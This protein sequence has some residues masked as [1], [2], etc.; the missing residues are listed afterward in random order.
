M[1]R[2]YQVTLSCTTNKYKPVACIVKREQTTDED[3]TLKPDIKREIINQGIK[4]I[5][6]KRLWCGKDLQR[7]GYLKVKVRLYD[8][9][10]IAKENE[11]RDNR[12]K[13]EKYNSG[14]WVRPKA[15]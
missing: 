4:T 2:E 14:E 1:K 5:C 15:K 12:I 11:E 7:Y 6:N 8:R 3:L 13:E 10:K 9:E